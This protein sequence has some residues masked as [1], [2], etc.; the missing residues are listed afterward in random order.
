MAFWSLENYF[1]QLY[2]SVI[3]LKENIEDVNIIFLTLVF[4]QDVVVQEVKPSGEET[5]GGH[6]KKVNKQQCLCWL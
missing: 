2:M 5:V 1:R 4:V 3:M 6:N